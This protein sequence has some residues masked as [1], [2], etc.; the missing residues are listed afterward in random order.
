M[1]AVSSPI[2][3]IKKGDI[4]TFKVDA[5]VNAAKN[6]LLGGS[7]VD[8]AIHEAAGPQLYEFCRTLNG[9]E[10]GDA[11]VSPGFDLPARHVIHTVGPIWYGGN[12]DEA[13]LLASCYRN[14]LRCA[15]EIGAKTI[16]FPAISTG[17]Y[18]YPL[19]AAT[20]IAVR[21]VRSV[22]TKVEHITFVAFDQHT[23]NAYKM[24]LSDD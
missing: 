18:G 16:A 24:V 22:T 13:E 15:D 2:L 19:K 21:T 20:Q 8:G 4:T 11:K 3:R 12:D 1:S 9:C 23:F 10:T 17:I 5:I 6:S 14:S 7:G